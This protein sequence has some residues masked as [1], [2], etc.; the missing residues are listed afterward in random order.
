MESKIV[1]S[2]R[3]NTNVEN[4]TYAINTKLIEDLDLQIENENITLSKES[5]NSFLESYNDLK[6]NNDELIKLLNDNLS[7][8]EKKLS[9]KDML[10]LKRLLKDDSR[11]K[12]LSVNL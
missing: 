10:M 3:V 7:D 2:E 4:S 6:S 1:I 5:L 9:K 12:N 8:L 11:I